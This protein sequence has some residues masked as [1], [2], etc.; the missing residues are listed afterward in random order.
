MAIVRTLN[1]AEVPEELDHLLYVSFCHFVQIHSLIPQPVLRRICLGNLMAA[2]A[3]SIVGG[4]KNGQVGFR[5]ALGEVAG[6]SMPHKD[7]LLL[8]GG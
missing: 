1:V 2:S 4:G 8:S 6:I 3:S 5:G 7:G